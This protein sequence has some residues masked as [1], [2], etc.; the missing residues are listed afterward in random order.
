ML[1]H[2]SSGFKISTYTLMQ[3][4]IYNIQSH[5]IYSLLFKINED[6][7]LGDMEFAE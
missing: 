1:I 5:N 2:C 4:H 7:W 6:L 3:S